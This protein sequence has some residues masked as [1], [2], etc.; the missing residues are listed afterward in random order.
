MYRTR[1]D[2]LAFVNFI[3]NKTNCAA[4]VPN[5]SFIQFVYSYGICDTS[6]RVYRSN[7][8]LYL[9]NVNDSFVSPQDYPAASQSLPVRSLITVPCSGPADCAAPSP[10]HL[11]SYSPAATFSCDRTPTS[12]GMYNITAGD[13]YRNSD[14]NLTTLA[15][16]ADPATSRS[17]HYHGDCATLLYK[18]ESHLSCESSNSDL[19]CTGTPPPP[20]SAPTAQ[21]PSAEP[22]NGSASV[23]SFSAMLV[24]IATL[25]ILLF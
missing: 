13:C 19:H 6:L 18:E 23:A 10:L 17:I 11:A 4:N 12:Y 21:T 1:S 20:P 2:G 24:I 8:V 3:G 5:P 7:S 22:S 15:E 9:A 14:T 25:A 16:C